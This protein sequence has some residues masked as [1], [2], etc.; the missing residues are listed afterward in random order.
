MSSVSTPARASS[1]ET[2]EFEFHLTD[3]QFVATPRQYRELR[4][5]IEDRFGRGRIATDTARPISTAV[6]VP[7]TL[8]GLVLRHRSEIQALHRP[9]V[10][11]QK[12]RKA[13]VP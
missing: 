12:I 3:L 11:R 9:T 13:T 5:E 4:A 10:R 8:A 6:V 2:S 1:H 7:L